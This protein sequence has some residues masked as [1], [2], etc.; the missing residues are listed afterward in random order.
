MHNDKKLERE[1]GIARIGVLFRLAAVRTGKGTPE[2]KRLAK[3]YLRLA[4]QISR[5]Y[6]IPLSKAADSQVCKKCGNLLVPGR[7]CTVRVS[8]SGFLAYLCECGST[9]KLF[10]PAKQK[11]RTL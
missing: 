10:I 9:T 11:S 7:N 5:H 8:S 4:G 1:V 6:K 2:D 3:R